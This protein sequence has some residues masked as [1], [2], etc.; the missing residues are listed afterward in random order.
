MFLYVPL[1][2][3]STPIHM[4]NLILF[5]TE[6]REHL[7]PLTATRPMAELRVG[8]MTLREKWTFELNG[9]ASYITKEYLADKYP[10]HIAENNILISAGV[11]PTETLVKRIL[12]LQLNEALIDQEELIAACLSNEQIQRLIDDVEIQ[13]LD[14]LPLE[15]SIQLQRIHRLWDIIR[16][17]D[18]ELRADF[19]RLTKDQ[20]SV[21]LSPTNTVLGEHP[22]FVAPGAKVECATI[23]TG[24][25]PVYIG[26]NV[27]IMEGC[28]LRGPIAILDHAVI[29][30]DAKI[31]GPTV[32]GPGCKAGGEITRSIMMAN[33]NKAHDGFLGDS[34]IGE[35]CNLGADTNNSNL[36]NN[37]SEVK[38][39]DYKTS[40]FERSGAQFIGLFMGDHSKCAINTMFNTGTVAGVFANIYGAGFQRNFIPDFSWG[41]PDAGYRTYKLQEALETAALV[42]ARRGVEL[43]DTEKAILE[44]IFEHTKPYR[45]WDKS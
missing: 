19:V 28:R 44:Y 13:Q 26:P 33:A 27:E 25:G 34:V 17:N 29:K 23:N 12:D 36:K 39:W 41:G 32:I 2:Q 14:G 45:S 16:Y 18:A 15:P 35:W 7:L 4:R 3:V 43:D 20:T 22:V 30:M 37:Y 6:A 21:P 1:R 31:Y 24:N 40:R 10:I 8:A 38:L 9:S 11:L 42:M 5:D